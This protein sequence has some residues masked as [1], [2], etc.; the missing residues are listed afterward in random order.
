MAVW[1]LACPLDLDGGTPARG[2]SQIIRYSGIQMLL[3]TGPAGPGTAG[4]LDRVL[5]KVQTTWA[6]AVRVF[7]GDSADLDSS[8]PFAIAS[9]DRDAC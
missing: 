1:I 7:R 6:Q 2:E 9:D 5:G 3:A 4:D 8:A